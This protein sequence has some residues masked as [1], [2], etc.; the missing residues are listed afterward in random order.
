MNIPINSVTFFILILLRKAYSALRKLSCIRTSNGDSCQFE[1]FCDFT[2]Q[3][4]NDQILKLLQEYK[5]GGLMI[6]KWGTT[7]LNQVVATIV[8]EKG[9]H[10]ADIPLFCRGY[11]SSLDE[12]K[13][14]HDLFYL[15]GVFPESED[16]GHRFA[17]Q[18]LTDCQLI[19]ILGSYI[20]SEYVLANVMKPLL[21]VNLD[22]FYAPWLF[23]NPWTQWLRD[24]RVVVVH[25]F[26][27]S[28][29]HQYKFNRTK[30]FKNPDVLPEFKSLRCIKAVQSIAGEATSFKDWFEALDYMK[31][32]IDKEDYD[33]AIIGCGAYGMS[34]AAHVKRQGKVGIHLAGWTQMLFG[35]YGERWVSQQTKYSHIINESWIRPNKNENVKGGANIEEG[36]YW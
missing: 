21:K 28:I 20:R 9:F 34:L 1:G 6:S 10:L 2:N 27:E 12:S 11:V 13:T 18:A 4:G 25:P 16:T 17:L 36:C 8:Q 19:D 3:E 14:Y 22:A 5:Q 15:S 35:V 24:K 30:I 23:K 32:E 29:E 7:E 31:S 26:V 33:V